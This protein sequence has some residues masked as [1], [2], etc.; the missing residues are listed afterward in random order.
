MK[1]VCRICG[2]DEDERRRDGCCRGGC[3]IPRE[4]GKSDK[5]CLMNAKSETVGY[6]DE[7][8]CPA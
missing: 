5:M 8:T 6:P 7:V 4:V 2:Y 3:K 1:L